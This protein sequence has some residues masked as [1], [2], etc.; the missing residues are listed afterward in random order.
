[1]LDLTHTPY[2]VYI[3]IIFASHLC[4]S[5]AHVTKLEN[6]ADFLETKYNLWF[7]SVVFMWSYPDIMRF[8]TLNDTRKGGL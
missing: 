8:S 3:L 7:D 5:V 6:E 4:T 2:F 1:M